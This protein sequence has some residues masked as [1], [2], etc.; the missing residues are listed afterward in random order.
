[1]SFSSWSSFGFFSKTTLH[2]CSHS[3]VQP[4]LPDPSL[5]QGYC[6]AQGLL[7]GCRVQGL[8][9]QSPGRWSRLAQ[10]TVSLLARSSHTQEEPAFL[11]PHQP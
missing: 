4:H 9:A 10:H 1:M 6:G 11:Q 7:H 5:R 8:T 2:V 3:L